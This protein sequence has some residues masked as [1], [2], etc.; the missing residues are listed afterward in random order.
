MPQKPLIFIIAGEASGD[1]LGAK[2]MTELKP[3][4]VS[5]AGIGGEEMQAQGLKSL[6][7]MKELSIIGISGIIKD[8]PNL[9]SRLRYTVKT[10]QSLKPDVV[11]TI[12]AP[13][14]SFRVMK[15]LHK[16]PNR[17]FLIHYVAPS[18]WAWRPWLAKKISRFLDGLFC[19]YPFEP[20]MFAKHG[21][22]SVFVGHPA[23]H[24]IKPSKRIK[25]DSNLLC[26]L[27]GSRSSEVRSLLPIFKETVC[28]IQ[29]EKPEL[30]IIIPTVPGVEQ[31]VREQTESWPMPVKIVLGEEERNIAFQQAYTAL[32][33][34]GT[35]SLQLAA[36]NIPFVIAYK[37]SKFNEFIGRLLIKTPWVGMVNILIS[38]QKFGCIKQDEKPWVPE[39]LQDD[40][41]P[42]KI[43]DSVLQLMT[44][45]KMRNAQLVELTQAVQFLKAPENIASRKVTEY[46]RL[47]FN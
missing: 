9:L 28:R 42:I 2:L 46:I 27:P 37:V 10:I 6:F 44:D 22:K 43:S 40:C 23:A 3:L 19:L 25:R 32:A 30:H 17:P 20:S 11:I 36:H 41:T 45:E 39:F 5:F 26:V 1:H 12:D 18:V 16:Q 8:L 4:D 15:K 21:L 35:V 14:F 47:P 38:F 34:S 13:E 29:S 24:P 31:Y 7:P 33:A